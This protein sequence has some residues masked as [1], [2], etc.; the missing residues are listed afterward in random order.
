MSAKLNSVTSKKKTIINR[1]GLIVF[2]LA[3]VF[4]AV[5]VFIVNI[6]YVE[7]DTWRALGVQETVKKDRE[8]LP[9]RGNIYAFDGQL[10][11]ASQPLYGIYMDFMAEG[12]KEDTLMKY[13]DD[14][15]LQL[16]KKFPERKQNEY[17]KVIMDGWKLSRKE[18][19][20]QKAAERAGSKKKIR[21][22]SRSIRIIPRDINYLELK[23]LRT[24]PFYKQRSNRSGLIAQ[25]K[26]MREKPFGRIAGR[27]IGSI[28]KDISMGGASGI[29]M[30]CDTIL[31]GYKGIKSRQKIQGQW[32]DVVEIPAQDGMDVQTTLDISIQEITEKALYAKLAETDA[33]SGCA[34]L[35]EV[36]TGEIKAIA[37]L[38]RL[39][40]GVYAEGNP[41][42]FSYMSEPGSTFKTISLMVALEDGVVTPDSEFQVGNGLFSYGGNVVRDHDWRKGKDKGMMTVA[43]GMYN[44]SNVVVSKMILKGYENN[45]EK[46]VQHLYDLGI[47]KKIEWDVPLKGKEGTAVIRHPS[48]K[49]RYWSRTTLPWMSFGYETQVPP[50]YI[51]MFYNGIANNG[52]MI[53]PF[54]IKS[55]LKDGKVVEEFNTDIINP[56][57]CSAKT[58]KEVQ[59]ILV[60]VM[61]DG[62]GK[63]AASKSF[64]TAGKTGTALIASG[65]GYGSGGYY[66]SFCGYFPADKPKYTCFVGLRR[67]KGSPSGGGMA[68]GVFKNI[69]EAVYSKDLF[70]IPQDILR[71]DTI[72]AEKM[73]SVKVGSF[74]GL[75]S[76]MTN[77]KLNYVP[78]IN[79]SDWVESNVTSGQII[80]RN[81]SAQTGHV[82]NVK[83][84]G[85]KDAVYALEKAGLKVRLKG[86]GKVT[87]Q[88]IEPN[89]K[90]IPGSMI[91]IELN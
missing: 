63:A 44:S 77:L 9:N 21:T 7:G 64:P 62:T 19:A 79:T 74:D 39:S 6:M 28:Y 20:Q 31:K 18:I 29:E 85:A 50:I 46:Y 40:E 35:M 25:E 10:L 15:S 5:V 48:D 75:Q 8:I 66:V 57:L 89:V 91:N 49:A 81:V 69:A 84:M 24:F 33:E 38:D 55:Y 59:D 90:A 88:S 68:G 26:T 12:I 53:K 58:L 4:I 16:S 45:P 52:K 54:I 78:P 23:E 86:A 32:I 30:K 3:L 73:P 43:K 56:M 51:L 11:A 80:L 41:N 87:G 83:G 27:T 17:K 72:R 67:P 42:A 70:Q 65:G 82:P 14:L 1:Y 61:T 76:V 2:L 34:I 37:N 71:N 22:K 36:E 47:T 60:G 13:V